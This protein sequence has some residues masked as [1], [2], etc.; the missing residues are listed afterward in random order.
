MSSFFHDASFAALPV[1]I[2]LLVLAASARGVIWAQIDDPRWQRLARAHLAPLSTWSVTAFITY[3]LALVAAGEVAT[4]KFALALVLA[5]AAA[6]VRLED[7]TDDVTAAREAAAAATPAWGG[8][9]MAAAAPRQATPDVADRGDVT[10]GASAVGEAREPFS[11]SRR[12]PT[13]SGSLWAGRG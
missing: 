5:V 3:A 4:G 1:A 10:P 7:E 6:V 8:P 12:A 9:A 2:V 13:P 11:S